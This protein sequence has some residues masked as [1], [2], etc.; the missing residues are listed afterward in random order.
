[1]AISSAG[2]VTANSKKKTQ[3]DQYPRLLA[4]KF[5][6]RRRVRGSISQRL[7]V[8]QLA[9]MLFPY[10]VYAE[11]IKLCAQTFQRDVSQLSCCAG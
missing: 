9:G 2:R 10:L 3:N 8:E 4:R 7:T 6:S 1:M 5:C 11:A